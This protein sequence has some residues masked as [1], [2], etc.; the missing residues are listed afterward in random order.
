MVG[1]YAVV[2]E[3]FKYIDSYEYQK[4]PVGP[5]LFD[6]VADLDEQHNVA[7]RHPHIV[8]TMRDLAD[9]WLKRTAPV[10]PLNYYK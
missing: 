9:R 4:N 3:R 6:L 2:M 7:S 5:V 8:A 1:Y 10:R